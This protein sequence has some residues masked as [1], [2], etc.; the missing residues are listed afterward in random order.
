MPSTPYDE[1]PRDPRARRGVALAVDM[2]ALQRV[3]QKNRSDQAPILP[4]AVLQG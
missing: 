1:T 3:P 4:Y 2:E